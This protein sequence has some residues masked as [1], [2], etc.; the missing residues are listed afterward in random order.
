MINALLQS[1]LSLLGQSLTPLTRL[2][3]ENST[4]AVIAVG[5][6]LTG[7]LLLAACIGEWRA[8]RRAAAM[9]AAISGK[10]G[11][12]RA[13]QTVLRGMVE[14]DSPD[15]R[16]VA[17]ELRQ[18][19]QVIQTKSGPQAQW[20]E[21]DR[22]VEAKPFYLRLE[23]GRLVRVEPDQRVFV[24][25]QLD[26]VRR[27]SRVT[28][29]RSAVIRHG[30]MVFAI[31]DLVEGYDPRAQSDAG[32]RG[33][34]AKTL[35]LRAS[36]GR[37]ML[38]STEAP[39]ER[40]VRREGFH[41]NWALV[42]GALMLG[43]HLFAFGTFELLTFTGTNVN[44]TVVERHTVLH[45][46]KNGSHLSYHL[47]AQYENVTGHNVRVTDEIAPMAYGDAM[48]NEGASVPFVVSKYNSNV[49]QIGTAPELPSV[50]LGIAVLL[51]LIVGFVYLGSIRQ[52]RPWYEQ[53]KVVEYEGGAL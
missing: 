46:T 49:A 47:S 22:T 33:T 39:S 31:G 45:R 53:R 43:I 20:T 24:V 44:A 12:L 6:V 4:I 41:G 35:V 16:A 15:G 17:V 48:T 21:V 14:S 10:L 13:G 19:G 52:S 36:K 30:D 9:R 38:L 37:S 18:V 2:S 25:D 23:D 5:L 51:S 29:T 42:L 27:D 34:R 32:Y 26:D 1:P 3:N 8:R 11:P 7:G 40:H 28:R 50:N